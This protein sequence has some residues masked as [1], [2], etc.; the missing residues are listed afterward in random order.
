MENDDIIKSIKDI[1]STN[2]NIPKY[3]RGYKWSAE[4]IRKLL[5]DI[6]KFEIDKNNHDKFYCLQNITIVNNNNSYDIIDGQQRLTTLFILL[7]YLKN[8]EGIEDLLE[9]K[10]ENRKLEYLI[11]DKSEEFMYKY[12]VKDNTDYIKEDN[13]CSVYS[14]NDKFNSIKEYDS[15]DIF[16]F[17]LAKHTIIKF[18]EN[19]TDEEKIE[20]A[21]KL[22]E[23]VKI[24]VNEVKAEENNYEHIFKNLNSNKVPLAEQD[25]IRAIFITRCKEDNDI[26]KISEKRLKIGCE[27][28]NMNMWWSKLSIYKYFSKFIK[29]NKNMEKNSISLL[30]NIFFQC[31]KENFDKNKEYKSL[32]DYLDNNNEEINNTL[33]EVLRFHNTMID[34]YKDYEIYHL[35]GFISTFDRK[36]ADIWNIWEK[37]IS[38]DE[39]KKEL[40]NRIKEDLKIENNLETYTDIET[41]CYNNNDVPLVKL[42][43]LMDI[44]KILK[45]KE[46]NFVRLPPEYFSKYD[47][48]IEHIFSKTPNERTTTIKEAKENID[49]IEK[50]EYKHLLEMEKLNKF[51]SEITKY[52]EK[53]ILSK[54]NLLNKYREL[55]LSIPVINSIGN[56]V[57]LN[58]SINRGYGNSEYEK[59]RNVIVSLYES[60]NKKYIRNHTWTIFTKSFYSNDSP[61]D[62]ESTDLNTWN[63]KDIEYTAKY[64]KDSIK[65]FFKEN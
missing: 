16:H 30:Y 20:F 38:R 65:N 3:Q 4:N 50:S 15:Q 23:N 10:Q 55:I 19:K 45:N 27:I 39:F 62:I 46:K 57:L 52:D 5:E 41:L 37:N 28:D 53:E 6:D 48:D 8:Y 51:K 54:L 40:K 42:L 1:F 29:D 21:K 58:S 31:F 63:L 25:F 34:W 17:A 64:I 14:Y 13:N 35:I 56:L 47:E 9:I 12:I 61:K 22:L 59:K 32:F 11:R 26:E 33:K 49:L 60:S 7:S 43:I 18:F 2:Y 44:I 24:I 36:I